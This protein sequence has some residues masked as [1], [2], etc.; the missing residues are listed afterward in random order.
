M[1]AS[2]S[3]P[4]S[5]AARRRTTSAAGGP[6]RGRDTVH[7]AHPL[8]V[9]AGHAL[10]PGH[11]VVQPLELGHADGA[12]DVGQAVVEAQARVHEPG[13]VVGAALVAQ[14]G[15]RAGELVVIGQD[16]AALGGRELLVG[17]EAVDGR[18][19]ERAELAAVVGTVDGLA[20]VLDAGRAR[21]ARRSPPAPAPRP[22]SRR[23]VNDQDRP[24]PGRDR[25][26]DRGRIHVERQR[27]N[28]GEDRRRTGE[29][30]R[31]GGCDEREGRG[32]DLVAGTD[33][34]RVQAQVPAGGAAREGDR[35]AH[36]DAL[37]PGALEARPHR[38]QRELARAQHLVH[39]LSLARADDRLGERDA[40]VGRG[41]TRQR[42]WRRA[43]ARTGG[44]RARGCPAA[45]PTRPR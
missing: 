8:L 12:M 9:P 37:G 14:A 23:C 1:T 17:V 10:A 24:R 7:L 27:V 28:L 22:G 29:E 32:D 25:G 5:S 40:V 16:D 3:R 39:Q 45:P 4:G 13:A 15:Q 42:P 11:H 35:V 36:A 41:Q 31:V 6:R 38:A 43:P 21:S 30:H 19:A 26:L 33:P 44:R 34:Q 18:V 20:G 2:R